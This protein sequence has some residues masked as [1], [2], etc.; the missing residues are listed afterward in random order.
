MTNP[1]LRADF[2]GLF[3]ELLCLSHRDTCVDENGAEIRLHE[4][5]TVTAFDEDTDEAGQRDDLLA[6]GVVE[7]SPDWLAC[8]GSRWV[9]RIDSRGVHHQSDLGRL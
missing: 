3:A 7:R 1:K 2:N 6:S 5:M 9:L 4:G 8:N